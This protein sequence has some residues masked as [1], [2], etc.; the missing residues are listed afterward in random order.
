MQATAIQVQS[1]EKKKRKIL[2][3][4]SC[5]AMGG[6]PILGFLLFGLAPMVISFYMSFTDLHRYDFSAATWAGLSN[7]GFIFKDP[8]FWRSILNTVYSCLT[9]PIQMILGLLIATVL[10]KDIK[11]MKFFRALYFIPY[12]CSSV[13]VTLMF[14]WLFDSELGI[15][16][17]LLSGIGIPKQE[18]LLNEAQF[19]PVMIIMMTWAGTGYYIILYQAALTNINKAMLEAAELD[20]AG[21][22]RRFFSITIPAVSPTT[23]YLV[24]MGVIGGLQNF[25]WFQVICSGLGDGYKYGPDNA[26]LTIVYYLYDKGFDNIVTYGM[27]I[28][29]AAAW[30]LVLFIL[31]LTALNF[32]GSKKWVHYDD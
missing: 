25:T 16:N 27:G 20:G 10:V 7:Y 9:I 31:A 11:G 15:V 32:F 21:A 14:Q 19:M 30:V 5:W 18:F 22:V 17:S 2:H 23:F 13:A 6:I 29:S 1:R 8:L 4:L 26:G 3:H 12:I 28:A 24:I